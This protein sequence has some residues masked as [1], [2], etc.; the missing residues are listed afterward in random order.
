MR[1]EDEDELNKDTEDAHSEVEEDESGD[2]RS[3]SSEG[4]EMTLTRAEYQKLVDERD[5]YKRGLLSAKAKPRSLDPKDEPAE[6]KPEKER[7]NV[8]IP[9]EKIR[10]VLYRE[11]ERRVLRDVIDAESA[12]Y[13][14]ELV[15]DGQYREIIQYLPKN[16]D[17]SSESSIRKSLK[18]AIHA[19]KYDKGYADDKPKKKPEADLAASSSKSHGGSGEER[20]S[21]PKPGERKLLKKATSIEDWYK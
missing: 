17:K 16:I 11:T 19:W 4:E 5:N 14:K 8:D 18:V 13:M 15:D 12:H 7:E 1:I 9:E 10:S 20:K 2:S 3:E 6:E 21:K